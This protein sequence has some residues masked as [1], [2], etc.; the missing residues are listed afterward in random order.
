MQM[1]VVMLCHRLESIAA[2]GGCQ[3]VRDGPFPAGVWVTLA[4]LM[5]GAFIHRYYEL[6]RK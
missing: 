5:T 6:R 1:Y 4:V 3:L 2:P